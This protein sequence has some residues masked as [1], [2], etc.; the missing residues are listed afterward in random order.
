VNVAVIGGTRFFGRRF[1]E[2]AARRGDRVTLFHRGQTSFELPPGVVEILGDRHGEA[3]DA[4]GATAWDLVLDTCGYYPDSLVRSTRLLAQAGRYLFVSSVSAYAEP[5][6]AGVTEEAA[7]AELPA[8][9]PERPD[10]LEYYGPLKAACEAVVRGAFGDRATIVRPGL[11]VG[12]YDPTDRFTYWPERIARGGDVL[13]P[14]APSN[15]VQFIDARD[16]AEFCLTLAGAGAGGAYNA[17]GPA[18]PLTME[19]FLQAGAASIASDR[20]VRL[21]WIGDAELLAAGVGPWMDLPLWLPAGDTLMQVDVARSLAAGL[22]LRPLEDTFL[23]T[24]LWARS[25]PP[26]R[27]RKAGIT[28]ER[29][30]ELLESLG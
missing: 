6:P 8:G 26:D 17:V 30:R 9:L 12:A 25:L 16:L 22:R 10:V 4:L 1:V 21:R 7:L 20:P 29:E 2:T 23:E 15:P 24:A 19:G 3:L 28:P 5:A 14:G 11:I 18:E 13:A 27:E